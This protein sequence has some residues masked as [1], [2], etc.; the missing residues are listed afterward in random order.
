MEELDAQSRQEL[1]ALFLIEL[2]EH[3]QVLT[4]AFLGL[5]KEPPAEERQLLLGE[6][7]RAAHSLKGAARAVGLSPVESLAHA[8]EAVLAD[9]QHGR[10]SLTPAL[11]DRLYAVVDAIAPPEHSPGGAGAEHLTGPATEIPVDAL[12][13]QLRAAQAEAGASDEPDA[14][15]T[16]AWAA[17]APAVE[18]APADD[19]RS[20]PPPTISEDRPAARRDPVRGSPETIRLP[21]ARLDT[22][23]EQLGELVVPR[24]ELTD[25]LNDLAELHQEIEGWQRDWRKIRSLLRHLDQDDALREL[26]PLVRFLERNET[27]LL[28]L[29][30][31][32]GQLRT[33]L[34]GS[35]G[36]LRALT[37]DLQDDVKRLRMLPFGSSADGFGRVVRDLA[38]SLGKEA[39]LVVSGA[40]TELDRQVLDA[41]KDSL[42]HLL[43]NSLDHGI[44]PPEVRRRLG[45]PVTGTVGLGAY[46]RGG[47]IVIE[48]EDDGAGLD[49]R[50]IRRA[51]SDLRL[52]PSTDLAS[53]SDREV[54]RLIFEPGLSTSHEVSQV[55]GRGVGLDVVARTV[56]RLGGRVDVQA[57]PGQGTLFQITLPLTLATARAL[58]FEAGDALYALDTS[59]IER[60]IRVEHL[61]N[62]GGR[63]MLEYEGMAVPAA[64]LSE[65][66]HGRPSL[67]GAPGQPQTVALVGAGSQR[68]GLVIDQVLGEQEIVVKPLGY[69]LQRVRFVSGATIL[70]SGQVVP[71]LN[72]ADL[73]RAA[74]SLTTALTMPALT[75]SLTPAEQRRLRVLVADDSLTT[76]TLERY[77]LEAAGYEVELAGDGL[78]ALA[79]LDERDCDV[80]VSDVDM[81]RLDGVA[82][83]VQVR[84][85]P[86]FRELPIILV[87]SLASAEDRERGLQAGADAYMVKSSFDQDQLLRTIQELV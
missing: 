33:R 28:A 43:R 50:V 38:R 17:L 37:D 1:R 53:M 41:I 5:E 21:A 9:L 69:P 35:L 25:G 78:E 45:K 77:I 70:G 32:I 82:L 8:L 52:L 3:C 46:Q 66:L 60:V 59:A 74:A 16:A 54:V 65:L 73:T 7:F 85:V 81:P 68:V 24:L 14:P 87:T 6:A 13:Q 51:A 75:P 42:L 34:G 40:D 83:T 2:G 29:N 19:H 72:V 30:G 22:L 39:R 56:E 63:L 80:L 47:T 84:Q 86:R 10:L 26:Q 27:S 20:A 36:Q 12:L 4:H 11:F 79:L 58:L 48:V 49:P 31:R 71:I 44:E 15:P 23:L 62:V 18:P 57:T 64:I 55:S 61:G 76:R 67:P